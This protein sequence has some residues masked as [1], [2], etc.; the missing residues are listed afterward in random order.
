MQTVNIRQLKSNPSAA[1]ASA[2]QEDMVI[3]TNR[4]RPQALLVDL[5]KLGLPNLSDVRVALAASLFKSGTISAGTAARMVDKPLAEMLTIL[6]NLGIPLT[7]T[8]E[9]SIEDLQAEMAAAAAWV[10]KPVP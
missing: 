3:I 9:E 8:P 6:S 10:V 4:D 2:R 1:L 5:E 7:G